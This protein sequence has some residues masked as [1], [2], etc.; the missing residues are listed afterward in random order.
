MDLVAH[1]FKMACS[2]GA[3]GGELSKGSVG[4]DFSHSQLLQLGCDSVVQFILQIIIRNTC[5]SSKVQ[6]F[7]EEV[8]ESVSRLHVELSELILRSGHSVR[9]IVDSLQVFEH[10]SG[11]FIRVHGFASESGCDVLASFSITSTGHV[12]T[13][14]LGRVIVVMISLKFLGHQKQPIFKS[15][16]LSIS[17]QQRVRDLSQ[18]VGGSC[19]CSSVVHRMQ[20]VIGNLVGICISVKGHLVQAFSC[21]FK[22]F[23]HQDNLAVFGLSIQL[24]VSQSGFAVFNNIFIL[25]VDY[26][27]LF[28]KPF[29]LLMDVSQEVLKGHFVLV[30]FFFFITIYHDRR[31][32]IW[33]SLF[34]LFRFLPLMGLATRARNI[35]W[36]GHHS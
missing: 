6:E 26:L 22:S 32:S 20:S 16:F 7:R 34:S 28:I 18:F 12:G 15:G 2:L 3:E 35:I 10:I 5:F 25:F 9:V 11:V 31:A 14:K 27:E 30:Q 19:T 8:M 24:R 17:E 33:F 1:D 23:L 29:R 36:S 13:T 4:V 21:F